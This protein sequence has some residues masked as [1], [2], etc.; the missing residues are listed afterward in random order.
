[1]TTRARK[2]ILDS[3]WYWIYA[4]AAVGLALL[5]LIRPKFAERQSNQ[6]KQHQA[7][8]RAYQIEQGKTPSVELSTA[9]NR[10]VQLKPLFF[11]LFVLMLAA[12]IVTW[13]THFYRRSSPGPSSP[14]DHV[15]EER[16]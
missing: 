14:D 3:P 15:E 6:E 5:L 7:R 2:S 10:K 11:F 9:E 1:M 12:W 8:Q 16:P 13:C 4:F